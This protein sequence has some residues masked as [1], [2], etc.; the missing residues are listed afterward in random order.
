MSSNPT[1]ERHSAMELLC[2]LEYFHEV[3]HGSSLQRTRACSCYEPRMAG[4][5]TCLAG[6]PD[7]PLKHELNTTKATPP[8]LEQQYS[9]SQAMN[10]TAVCEHFERLNSK[11]DM[12]YTATLEGMTTGMWL[13]AGTTIAVVV[14]ASVA[15]YFVRREAE[16]RKAE[17]DI[18]RSE[19]KKFEY[20]VKAFEAACKI[21]KTADEVDCTMRTL[22][23]AQT[24]SR[25][26]DHLLVGRKL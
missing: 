5:C 19:A 13:I 14:T 6:R 11:S 26:V 2:S 22:G 17:A 3:L 7:R 21:L 18:A 10:E 12:R 16:G 9:S 1:A 23:L 24:S 20:R 15:W 8:L 4:C 25:E